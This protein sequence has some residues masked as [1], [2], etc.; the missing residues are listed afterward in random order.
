MAQQTGAVSNY[1]ISYYTSQSDAQTQTAP[2]SNVTSYVTA[3]AEIWIRIANNGTTCFN[4]GS[5]QVVVNTPLSLTTPLPLSLCDNV[6]NPNNQFQVFNLTVKDFEISGGLGTV[7]YYPSLLDAQNGTNVITTPTAYQNAPAYPAV[8]TLGVVVTTSA[9]CKSIT[10]L[11]I[12]VEPLPTLTPPANVIEVCDS[13]QDGFGDFNLSSLVPGLLNG[14]TTYVV[15]FHETLTDAQLD[16][17]AIN[18]SISYTTITPLMQMLYVR[19]E[20]T[21]TGCWSTLTITL[22]VNPSPIAPINLNPITVCD[23]DATP[24][25]GITAVDL[26]QQQAAILAQQPLPAST[27]T[28]SYYT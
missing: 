13:N 4:T 7:T 19:A 6:A 2:I 1:T 10:T 17:N 15:S 24:Q 22:N 18:T 16:V 9:G 26:S 8:Q 11:D 14:I 20:D 21:I 27:Y 28:I 12:R 23:Q 3:S 5:F 25:D